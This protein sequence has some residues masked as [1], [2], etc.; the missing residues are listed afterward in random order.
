MLAA[1][2]LI[3]Q[4]GDGAEEYAAQKLLDSIRKKDEENPARWLDM[5][6][7]LKRVRELKAE[8]EYGS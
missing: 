5:L 6:L 4:A 3:R 1:N 2:T 7:A 8:A